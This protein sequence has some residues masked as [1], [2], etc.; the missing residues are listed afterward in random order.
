MSSSRASSRARPGDGDV[1]F[2]PELRPDDYSADKLEQF[3]KAAGARTQYNKDLKAKKDALKLTMNYNTQAYKDALQQWRFDYLVNLMRGRPGV[4]VSVTT[5]TSGNEITEAKVNAMTVEEARNLVNTA[6][7][8]DFNTNA[9]V[10]LAKRLRIK[11]ITGSTVVG[12]RV[13]ADK[14][15]TLKDVKLKQNSFEFIKMKLGLPNRFAPQAGAAAS[16]SR[17]RTPSPVRRALG[18]S[19]ERMGAIDLTGMTVPELK[20]LAAERGLT[21]AKSGAGGKSSLKADYIAAL[22]GVSGISVAATGVSKADAEAEVLRLS[23]L[24][25]TNRT[26]ALQEARALSADFLE[27]ASKDKV[28]ELGKKLGYKLNK[29][30]TASR[31]LFIEKIT[32]QVPTAARISRGRLDIKSDR[33]SCYSSDI[34]TV[35]SVAES[36][37]I[38]TLGLT[39]EQ[40][41]DRIFAQQLEILVTRIATKHAGDIIAAARGDMA[42]AKRLNTLLGDGQKY[43]QLG[44]AAFITAWLKKHYQARAITLAPRSEQAVMDYLNFGRVDPANERDLALVFSDIDPMLYNN[45]AGLSV[46]YDLTLSRMMAGDIDQFVSRIGMGDNSFTVA[47]TSRSR[48]P[49]ARRTTGPGSAPSRFGSGSRRTVV[50][51][52]TPITP[53]RIPVPNSPSYSTS[54]GSRVSSVSTSRS[55]SPI[56]FEAEEEE[57]NEA[58]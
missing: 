49:M 48:S 54:S 44:V 16:R 40:I 22:S 5:T 9:I 52:T 53:S 32:G 8:T 31:K 1:T 7:A 19:R 11:G 57:Y 10:A 55:T 58:F 28:I 45:P 50:A 47:S 51:P 41:C 46:L 21:V 35:R 15:S 56:Q 3:I 26:R 12:K 43:D 14:E 4:A 39:K 2:Q 25:G 33:G 30:E 17:E 42:A 18:I 24:A 29:G 23:T 38:A 27:Q 36:L 20:K 37:G 34:E 6:S 13:K